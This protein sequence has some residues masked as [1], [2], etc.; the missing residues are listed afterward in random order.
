MSF[1]DQ[2]GSGGHANS[3][4][5]ILVFVLENNLNNGDHCLNKCHYDYKKSFLITIPILEQL[6]L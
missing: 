1:P 2:K 4:V 6:L 5:Q 3:D